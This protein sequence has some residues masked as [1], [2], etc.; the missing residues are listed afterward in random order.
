MRQLDLIF[1]DTRLPS[2]DGGGTLEKLE[3]ALPGATVV[4]TSGHFAQ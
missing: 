2:V 4:M 3:Q 1:L